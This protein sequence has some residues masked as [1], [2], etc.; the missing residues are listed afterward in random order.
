M[1]TSDPVYKREKEVIKL[2][3]EEGA[4]SIDDVVSLPNLPFNDDWIGFGRHSRGPHQSSTDYTSTFEPYLWCFRSR[5]SSKAD[6]FIDERRSTSRSHIQR[7]S[8]RLPRIQ[9]C[10]D[11]SVRFVEYLF[12][13]RSCLDDES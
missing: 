1:V 7:S 11:T 6:V 3:G 5:H 2:E 13:N 10:V 8:T 4:S 9:R 12:E